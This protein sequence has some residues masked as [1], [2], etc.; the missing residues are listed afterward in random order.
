MCPSGFYKFPILLREVSLACGYR[1]LSQLCSDLAYNAT[2]ML[3]Y[4]ELCQVASA[5]LCQ[6]CE[7]VPWI[8]QLFIDGLSGT[9]PP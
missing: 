3:Y 8:C 9:L 7:A 5:E 1:F 4:A 6:G 2:K